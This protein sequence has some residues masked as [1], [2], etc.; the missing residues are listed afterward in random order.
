M[1]I[2]L[3]PKLALLFGEQYIVFID[4]RAPFFANLP[5]IGYNFQDYLVA[6]DAIEC[7]EQ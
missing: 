1:S 4:Y 7:D 6:A 5:V 3:A 2:I